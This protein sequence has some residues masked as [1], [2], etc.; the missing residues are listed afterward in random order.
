M[1]KLIKSHCTTLKSLF[2]LVVDFNRKRVKRTRPWRA[3]L[4]AASTL[5]STKATVQISKPSLEE[6]TAHIAFTLPLADFDPASYP[7]HMICGEKYGVE[8][9][10]Y[11]T[12]SGH[13]QKSLGLMSQNYKEIRTEQE[14]LEYG[15]PREVDEV[16]SE[17][18]S[19]GESDESDDGSS[20]DGEMDG[21]VVPSPGR[22]EYDHAGHG[23]A[24]YFNILGIMR[25]ETLIDTCHDSY[26]CSSA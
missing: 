3:V 15:A 1:V 26:L 21:F 10:H 25:T 7:V 24:P 2:L 4:G 13:L 23:E 14:Q 5:H 19:D 11:R 17:S 12:V 16:G 22:C 20:D 18:D 9:L 6:E 8:G